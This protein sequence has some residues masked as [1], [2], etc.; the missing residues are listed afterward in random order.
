M[1][2]FYL[3]MGSSNPYH[4]LPLFTFSINESGDTVIYDHYDNQWYKIKIR[5]SGPYPIGGQQINCF[6]SQEVLD[7]IDGKIDT[8][9]QEKIDQLTILYVHKNVKTIEDSEV[10]DYRSD[11][12]KMG[13]W[14]QLEAE[15]GQPDF[16]LD[17]NG[18]D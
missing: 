9:S 5:N 12:D 11:S 14:G 17:R 10:N 18:E 1:I 16:N 3:D 2:E 8:L 15:M 7:Y 6:Y 4:D 13:F